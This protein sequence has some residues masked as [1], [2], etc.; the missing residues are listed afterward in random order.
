MTLRS[1]GQCSN[2]RAKPAR[3]ASGFLDKTVF[4]EH[5]GHK[6]L[7]VAKASQQQVSLVTRLLKENPGPVPCLGGWG[8]LSTSFNCPESR[9]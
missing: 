2:H 8:T 9:Q 7:Q 5:T 1:A 3:A 4:P 6:L